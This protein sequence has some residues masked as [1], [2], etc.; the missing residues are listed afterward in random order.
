MSVKPIRG[1]LNL[2]IRQEL[3]GPWVARL[4]TVIYVLA[5][6]W[7]RRLFR[8]PFIAITGSL[9]KTTT[10]ECLAAVL[11]SIG[12]T[13]RTYRNQNGPGM[14]ALNLLRVRPWHRYAVLEI[15][16]SDP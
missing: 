10:K 2:W 9:G 16:A 6:L 7:R 14:V 15:A 13:Y 3:L 12:P 4:G 5:F 11:E 8:P 1:R